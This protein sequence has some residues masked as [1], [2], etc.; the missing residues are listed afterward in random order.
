MMKWWV[1]E[2]KLRNF[3]LNLNEKLYKPIFAKRIHPKYLQN[4]QM[5][6]SMLCND[7]KICKKLSELFR[8]KFIQKSYCLI[9]FVSAKE[10]AE[11]LGKLSLSCSAERSLSIL[12]RPKTDQKHHGIRSPQS[13]GTVMYWTCLCQQSGYWKSDWWVFIRKSSFQVLFPIDFYTKQ[14]EWFI[15]NLVKK[16]N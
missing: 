6:L 7:D 16:V 1:N 3:T 2:K 5:V 10:P 15:L 9:H 4:L 8:Y 14:R 13:S 11:M 12:Q